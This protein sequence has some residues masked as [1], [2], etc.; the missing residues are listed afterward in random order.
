HSSKQDSFG[1][2]LLLIPLLGLLISSEFYRYLEVL[3]RNK[4]KQ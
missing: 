1:L 2:G 4:S 3:Y